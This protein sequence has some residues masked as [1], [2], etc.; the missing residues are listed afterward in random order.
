MKPI[1]P[2]SEMNSVL[3]ICRGTPFIISRGI[4]DVR[5]KEILLPVRT[6]RS[7][8]TSSINDARYGVVGNTIDWA[9]RLNG[10]SK[11]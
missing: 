3:Y 2:C 9:C 5:A 10:S 6:N 7:E 8:W 1:S 4:S 11:K